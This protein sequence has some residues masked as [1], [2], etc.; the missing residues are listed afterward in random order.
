MTSL[1]LGAGNR[2]SRAL[3]LVGEKFEWQPLEGE[4]V[5][6]DMDEGCKPDVVWTLGTWL[7]F[8]KNGVFDEIHAYEI[9]EHVGKQGDWRGFFYEFAEYWR[10]LKPGGKLIGTVPRWDSEWAWGDPGHTRVIT[11]GTLAFLSQAEYARQIGKTP[12]TDYRSVWTR[13]FGI[14]SLVLGEGHLYFVLV[15]Q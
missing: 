5:R 9:L 7:P 4:V 13:D 3:R 6:L 14:E 2:P 11:P 8:H 10:V 12:M 1:I 15:K